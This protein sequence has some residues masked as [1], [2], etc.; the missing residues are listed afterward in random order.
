MR[1][2]EFVYFDL[3]NVI[4]NF[5]H[6]QAS[7]NVSQLVGTTVEKNHQIIFESGLQQQY[8]SGQL[9]SAEYVQAFS[10]QS[11]TN[12]AVNEFC[13][14]VSDIFFLNRSIIPVITQLHASGFPFAILSNTCTAHWN[15][16]LSRF[17]IINT[18]FSDRENVLSF[19]AKVMKPNPEIY[20]VAIE[21]AAVNPS[22][23]FFVDD[24]ADNVM[25][26]KESGIQSEIYQ[27]PLN[28]AQI[29]NESGV[30]L[31]L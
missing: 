11:G 28:L 25:G 9:T 2:I 29:L 8:E 16:V 7:R 30:S 4:V 31:N 24:R 6:Q 3:G 27:S 12:P 14:A 5:D 15:Y 10:E 1:Q 26:A 23:V 13:F 17:P 19:E 20:Q 21:S 18:F 22:N